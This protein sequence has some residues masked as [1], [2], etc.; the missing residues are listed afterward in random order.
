MTDK[1]SEVVHNLSESFDTFQA[2]HAARQTEL[3]ERLENLEAERDRPAASANFGPETT[4]QK[5][6]RA[7]FIQWMRRPTDG[8]T[9]SRLESAQ[10]DAGV[11]QKDVVVGTPASGGYAVPEQLAA[12]IEQR[13]KQLN[14]F[15]QYV[16]VDQSSTSDYKVLLDLADDSAGW[17]AETGT[18][19]AT[20]TPNL[21]EIAP[22]GGELYA[23]PQASEWAMQDVFFD[24]GQWLVD[25]CAQSF[26]QLEHEA[27]ISGNGTNR[28]TGILNTTP[29]TTAD[30]ASPMRAAAALQYIG[31]TTPSSPLGL[32]FDDLVQLMTT[33]KSQYLQS[34][35]V[36][37]AM[38]R[39]TFA[40]VK[41]IKSTAGD[42]I[43][44]AD[45][46]QGGV[47][48]ILGF[49]IV[50]SDYMPPLADDANI[51]TFGDWGRGYVLVDRQPNLAIT[52]DP[53]T[54]PGHIRFYVR[55][56]VYGHVLNND[57]LKILQLSD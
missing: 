13:V 28:P 14:P 25:S 52:V 15:R 1:I 37:W 12:Q 35:R 42:Y 7:A 10:A 24:V 48:S 8:N 26:S 18:R 34:D 19:S 23:Y 57:A 2:K 36:A 51:I 56:R 17:V 11:E 54:N 40:Q 20:G 16:R 39:T 38:H 21:R 43:F 53:Y 9:K 31:L 4:R 41:R 3:A 45:P 50:L 49:P 5:E 44:S 33:L 6:H 30:D 47:G 55:R 22:T 46:T 27:I 32:T 29:V